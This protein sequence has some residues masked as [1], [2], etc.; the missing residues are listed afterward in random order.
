MRIHSVVTVSVILLLCIVA[1][2]HGQDGD[3]KAGA[4][5]EGA[6]NTDVKPGGE[7]MSAEEKE[8]RENVERFEKLFNAHDAKGL[9]A[10]FTP[11]AEMINDDGTVTKGR[12]AI[13]QLLSDTFQQSP[14]A[15]MQ[16]DV[17]TVRVLS[18]N[19]AIEEGITRAKESPDDDEEVTSYLAIH[20]KQ[21]GKWLLASVRDW[22]E[23]PGEL[24]PHDRLQ[25]LAWLVGEWIEQTDDSVVQTVCKWQ[26]ND[27]FLM[28]EFSVRIGGEI[29]MS[30]TMRIGWD[31]LRN[32]FKSWVFDTQGGYVEGYWTHN[33]DQWVVKS[34]GATGDGEAAS[35]TTVYRPV[36]PDTIVWRSFDRVVDGESREDIAPVTLKRRPPDPSESK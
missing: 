4:A 19:L 2:N 22:G 6:K 25:E 10:M 17:D 12:E 32:Q 20:A 5:K 26:D 27:N 8:V 3:K 7:T 1:A 14:K 29:A 36:D 30:G 23:P 33:N 11:H 31:P 15:S 24:T 13:E 28:Q 9:A 21:D 34:Q 35:A 16:I 18:P